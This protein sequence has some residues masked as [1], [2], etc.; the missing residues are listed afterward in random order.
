MQMFDENVGW[1]ADQL[2]TNCLHASR[3][4]SCWRPHGRFRNSALK[5]SSWPGAGREGQQGEP[6]GG[7]QAAQHQGG[8]PRWRFAG[9]MGGLTSP[10]S[11]NPSSPGGGGTERKFN[12]Q[13]ITE[14]II[15]SIVTGPSRGPQY[16]GGLNY[17][18]LMEAASA[19]SP[20]S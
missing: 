18:P 14:I 20:R 16:E 7:G 17:T 3:L 2:Q 19:H 11:W 6:Q 8:G 10:R 1:S 5:D 15:L 4:P 9:E 12:Q 13:E